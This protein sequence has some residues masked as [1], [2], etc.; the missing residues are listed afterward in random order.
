MNSSLENIKWEI[1]LLLFTYKLT[2]FA[3]VCVSNAR[4]LTSK[5]S[6]TSENY[7]HPLSLFL[8]LIALV[9]LCW[10]R[11]AEWFGLSWLRC[12][13]WCLLTEASLSSFYDFL[14]IS[15]Y[16]TPLN[17]PYFLFF[18]NCKL[19]KP[20]KTTKHLSVIGCIYRKEEC[21]SWSTR[22]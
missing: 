1:L 11:F 6:A 20:C 5:L 8:L 4:I 16:F 15:I 12:W 7:E 9:L 18:S 19:H 17:P 14:F 21:W 3:K 13:W 22:E 2:I 10:F